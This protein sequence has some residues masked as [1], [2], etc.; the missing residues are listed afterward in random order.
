M[1]NNLENLGLVGEDIH[2]LPDRRAD[3]RDFIV[4]RERFLTYRLWS[5][6][7]LDITSTYLALMETEKSI[8]DSKALSRL[9]ILGSLF[10]R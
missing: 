7:L 9:T 8:S 4:I 5:E 6:K 1:N 10:V 2:R 3:D